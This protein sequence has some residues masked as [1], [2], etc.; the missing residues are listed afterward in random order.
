MFTLDETAE[1]LSIPREAL[2]LLIELGRIRRTIQLD[3]PNN[4]LIVEEDDIPI[5]MMESNEVLLD[6]INEFGSPAPR[7]LYIQTCRLKILG[8]NKRQS[9]LTNSFETFE[10]SDVQLFQTD[11]LPAIQDCGNLDEAIVSARFSIEELER[12]KATQIHELFVFRDRPDYEPFQ[13]PLKVEPAAEAM[14]ELGNRF[15]KEHGCVPTGPARLRK[16]MCQNH[17]QPWEVIDRP[18]GRR[19]EILIESKPISYESFNK[20]FKQYQENNGR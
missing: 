7:F 19:G 4:F 1:K 20:R 13:L 15:Y 9:I 17:N 3:Q 2:I 5:D 18:N 11:G 14:V 16:Y 8:P 6:T 12:Y 10:G